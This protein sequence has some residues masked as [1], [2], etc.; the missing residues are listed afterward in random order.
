MSVNSAFKVIKI[1]DINPY[2]HIS[3]ETNSEFHRIRHI[4]NKNLLGLP[5]IDLQIEDESFLDPKSV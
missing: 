4:P 5:T 3:V 1:Y 2:L